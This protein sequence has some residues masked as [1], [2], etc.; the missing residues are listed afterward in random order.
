MRRLL[1]PLLAALALPTFFSIDSTQPVKA[2][3]NE[4]WVVVGFSRKTGVPSHWIKVK[5]AKQ[6]NDDSF[7]IPARNSYSKSLK[8]NCRNKDISYQGYGWEQIAGGTGNSAIASI[9]CRFIPAREVWGMSESNSYLWNA[10]A[11]QDDPASALGEWVEVVNNDKNEEYYNDKVLSD[12]KVVIFARYT[13]DKKTDSGEGTQRD[14]EIYRWIIADCSSNRYFTWRP[15]TERF[16]KGFWR[17][18]GNARPKSSVMLVRRK[19][20]KSPNTS[21]I[22]ALP[23]PTVKDLTRFQ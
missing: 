22:G 12:G 5:D 1:L 21:T 20:C 9:M 15:T 18:P 3:E 19:Y 8:I 11:P 14:V 23:I 7:K 4:G 13:R 17:T 6:I 16:F 10:P 2:K